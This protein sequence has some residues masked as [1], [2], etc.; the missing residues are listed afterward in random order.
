MAL[1]D[2]REDIYGPKSHWPSKEEV[3]AFESGKSH[4]HV[5]SLIGLVASVG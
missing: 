4:N 1:C 3:Q 5:M 2:F